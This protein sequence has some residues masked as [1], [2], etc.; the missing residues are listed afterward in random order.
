MCSECRSAIDN[1][2]RFNILILTEVLKVTWPCARAR[3]VL[4]HGL[5][6]CFLLNIKECVTSNTSNLLILFVLISYCALAISPF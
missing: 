1:I 5:P 3:S 2:K 6:S 4:T